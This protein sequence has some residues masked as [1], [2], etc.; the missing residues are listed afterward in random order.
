MNIQSDDIHTKQL[1]DQRKEHWN[2]NDHEGVEQTTK[3]IKKSIAK[4]KL[5]F[6]IKN[7]EEELWYDIKKRR[8]G[9]YL[10]TRNFSSLMAA[11]QNL[12]KE[13][14]SWLIITTPSNGH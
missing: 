8:Q 1:F 7:L 14:R 5:N 4:D 3:E 12:Q 10:H 11:W 9:F 13:L 6:K 2:N